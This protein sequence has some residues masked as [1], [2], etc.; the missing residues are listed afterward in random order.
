[1]PWVQD[2]RSKSEQT[3]RL[4]FHATRDVELPLL[5]G[6]GKILEALKDKTLPITYCPSIL[7]RDLFHRVVFAGGQNDMLQFVAANV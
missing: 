6:Q 7:K 4:L 1:M 5:Q 3:M 2:D